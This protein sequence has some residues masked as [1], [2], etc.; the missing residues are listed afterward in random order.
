MISLSN[1][2][3]RCRGIKRRQSF[4]NGSCDDATLTNFAREK[5]YIGDGGEMEDVKSNN[6]KF[7][8]GLVIMATFA[9]ILFYAFIYLLFTSEHSMSGNNNGLMDDQ[10]PYQN[11]EALFM[12]GMPPPPKPKQQ[13]D[14]KN[15]NINHLSRK[16]FGGEEKEQKQ[17]NMGKVKKS[18]KDKFPI[19]DNNK[20]NND[21][22]KKGRKQQVNP[23]KYLRSHEGRSLMAPK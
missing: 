17:K 13:I 10:Q 23:L 11:L 20:F 5:C 9:F 8:F 21:E 7:N 3:Y 14:A 16:D 22:E 18:D 1:L 19:L 2:Y 4:D 15:K 6:T 12:E